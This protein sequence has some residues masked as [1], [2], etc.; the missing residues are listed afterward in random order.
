MAIL[1]FIKCTIN[2]H[3]PEEGNDGGL[4]LV[5]ATP[6]SVSAAIARLTSLVAVVAS[7]ELEVDFSFA[8]AR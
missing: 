5:V 8:A 7:W 2:K 4:G 1:V 3:R 6:V